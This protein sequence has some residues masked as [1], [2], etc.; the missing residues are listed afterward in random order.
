MNRKIAIYYF[1]GTGNTAYVVKLARDAFVR[2][3]AGVDLF[4]IEDLHRKRAE[5][6]L[7]GYDVLGIAHPVLGFDCPG[8]IYDFVRTLPSAENKPVFLLK[9][10]GDYHAVNHSA[11]HSI[12]KI[13][14]RKGYDPFYDEIVAMPANWLMAYDDRLNRQLVEAAP[15][16]VAAAVRRILAGERQK[17]SNGL[18]LRIILRA[19]GYLEDQYG[20]KQFGRYLRAGASCTRCG[21]CA[22]DCPTG[23]I[24][25]E[26]EEVV[27]DNACV[28]CMRCIYNC[29]QKAIDNRYMNLFILKGGYSLARIRALA[30]EP[31]D[32]KGPKLSFWHKYFQRYFDE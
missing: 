13:L 28:W 20:A 1:S 4:K 24:E 22:R 10:A 29:P 12:K 17:L 31:I 18:L 8:F 11:S 25:L 2:A 16:R 23:N 9:T 6:N 7:A 32:F 5:F 30:F 21:K 15:K 14:S 27:F 19:I 3:G 26:N